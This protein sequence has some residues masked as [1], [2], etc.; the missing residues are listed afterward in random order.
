MKKMIKPF[1][2]CFLISCSSLSQNMIKEGELRL[3]GSYINNQSTSDHL[4]FKRFSW[5]QELTLNFDLLISYVSKE[6]SFYQ[7]F[8]ASE[9]GILKS[10]KAVYI[11]FT[12]ELDSKRLARSS[13]LNQFTNNGLENTETP[14][15]QREIRMHPDFTEE[16]LQLYTSHVLCANSDKINI[17]LNFPGFPLTQIRNIHEL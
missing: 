3:K 7:K 1:I 11:A 10:C 16:S 13:L 9:Q 4:V 8:A 6:S 14:R 5:Y 17:S 2:L 15:F 12:Y